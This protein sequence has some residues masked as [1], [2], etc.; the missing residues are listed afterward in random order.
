MYRV[1][2][3]RLKN[4]KH[5]QYISVY[6]VCL[7]SGYTYIHIHTYANALLKHITMKIYSI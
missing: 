7:L 3:T 5:I 4:Q 1:Y 2:E 6:N